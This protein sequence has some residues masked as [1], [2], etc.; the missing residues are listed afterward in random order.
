MLELDKNELKQSKID[1]NPCTANFSDLMEKERVD[2]QNHRTI[3]SLER[4]DRLMFVDLEREARA[5]Q[6]W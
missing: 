6:N 5:I 2:M 3:E 4:Y 1:C